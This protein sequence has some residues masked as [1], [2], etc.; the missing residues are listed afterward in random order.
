MTLY[1]TLADAREENKAESTEADG[2]LISAL[3][4]VSKRIDMIMNGGAHR[5]RPFFAPTLEARKV[6]ISPWHVSTQM[7]LLELPFPL[8]SLTSVDASGTALVIGTD[9]SPYPDASV[10]P[11]TDLQLSATY[12]NSWYTYCSS[13]IAQA[14]AT[15]TGIWGFHSTYAYAWQLVDTLRAAIDNSTT[16]IP[17]NTVDSAGL[18]G[19]TPSFSPGHLIQIDS[20]WMNVTAVSDTAPRTLTVETRGANGSTAANHLINSPIKVWQVEPEIR[21]VVARQAAQMQAKRGAYET[22]QVLPTGTEVRYD[23]D[24][25]PALRAALAAYAYAS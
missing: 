21:Y 3:R 16:T 19:N 7:G 6:L 15:I 18:D 9:V 20:E 24:L 11:F 4:T 12:E 8:L 10:P 23:A 13:T 5:P 17:V 14:Y 22:V 2:F 25:I 1:A